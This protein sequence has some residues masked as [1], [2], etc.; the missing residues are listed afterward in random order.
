MH[1]LHEAPLPGLR[2]PVE[3]GAQRRDRALLLVPQADGAPHLVVDG[4]VLMH[5]MVMS[6][7][8]PL[9]EKL[10]VVEFPQTVSERT[11]AT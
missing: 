10:P 3:R 4:P 1:Q 7:D 9:V 8:F 6:W 11:N 5:P 2:R